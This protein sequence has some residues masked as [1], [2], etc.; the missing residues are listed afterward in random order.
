MM[1]EQADIEN[2]EFFDARV[3]I[4]GL[5][6]VGCRFDGCV[7]VSR[8]DPAVTTKLIG[9]SMDS[10]SFEGDGWPREWLRLW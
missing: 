4:T 8:A 1:T 6:I 10:C 5:T 9:C 7:L 2:R 3:D